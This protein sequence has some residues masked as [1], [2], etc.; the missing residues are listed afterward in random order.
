MKLERPNNV[1]PGYYKVL[2]T[3]LHLLAWGG[4]Y[5]SMSL[6]EVM[7]IV[8]PSIY[9]R[10]C[11]IAYNRYGTPVGF[12]SYGFFAADT[13]A[14]WRQSGGHRLESSEFDEG[15]SLWVTCFVCRL[16]YARQ[17]ARSARTMMPKGYKTALSIRARSD[18]VRKPVRQWH[19]I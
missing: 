15:G 10:Q 4:L 18:G 5:S 6:D 14:A 16:G 1:E 2:G 9:H 12:L 8:A 13:D 3:I 19:A 17:F 7:D 11:L